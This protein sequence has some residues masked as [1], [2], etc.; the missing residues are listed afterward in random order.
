[1]YKSLNPNQRDVMFQCLMLAN[2]S[3]NEWDFGGEIISCKPGQFITSLDSL[4]SACAQQ[5][6]TKSVRT[7]L[8]KL[9]KWGFLANRS[10]KTGR[11]IT[12]CK[13]DTYQNLEYEPGKDGGKER[14]KHGQR[15][16]KERAANKNGKNENNV[17]NLKE[18]EKKEKS[19]V[20]KRFTPPSLLEVQD[21]ISSKDFKVNALAFIDYYQ[22]NGWKVSRNPMK[23]WQASVRLWNR[24]NLDNEKSR[25]PAPSRAKRVSDKLDQIARDAAKRAGIEG[26]L[27]ECPF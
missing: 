26:D 9:E 1:M 14:A 2:H 13:W 16:G 3:E 8:L 10:T 15:A 24:R 22:S 23:D 19:V 4:S 20:T 12:I 18:K 11:L 5:V 17:N 6:K 21:Y 25:Q 27:G 7:A